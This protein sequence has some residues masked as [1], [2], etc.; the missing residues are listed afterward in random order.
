MHFKAMY[1]FNTL[2]K[3]RK[4]YS[5]PIVCIMKYNNDDNYG[6]N[7]HGAFIRRVKGGCKGVFGGS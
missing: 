5:E 4:S 2:H 3:K 7:G 6:N 1:L